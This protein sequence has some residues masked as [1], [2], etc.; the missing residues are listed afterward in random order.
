MNGVLYS[1]FQSA[2]IE[3]DIKGITSLLRPTQP[4]FLFANLIADLP[5]GPLQV[6]ER[7]R[8]DLCRDFTQVFPE[9]AADKTLLEIA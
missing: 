9:G 8:E 4:R 2:V 7:F 5:V 1:T 3:L 6:W